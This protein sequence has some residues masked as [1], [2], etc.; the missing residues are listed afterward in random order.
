MKLLLKLLLL[1]VLTSNCRKNEKVILDPCSCSEKVICTEV[2][3]CVAVVI[4]NQNGQPVALDDYYTTRMAT[5]EK[6]NLKTAESD[7]LRN[8]HGKYPILTDGQKRLTEKCGT[9]FEFTGIKN[10]KEIIK[11]TYSIGHDCC[12]VKILKGDTSIIISD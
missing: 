9:D 1:I 8:I 3:I 6:I 5:G 2:Y 10:G 7:S 12:H 11:R 4:K